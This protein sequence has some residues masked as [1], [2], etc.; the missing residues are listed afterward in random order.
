ML[1]DTVYLKPSQQVLSLWSRHPL[2][3][4]VLLVIFVLVKFSLSSF[5]LLV[6]QGVLVHPINLINF[7]VLINKESDGYISLFVLFI[8]TLLDLINFPAYWFAGNKNGLLLPH[9][10]TDQGDSYFCYLCFLILSTLCFFFNI[11]CYGLLK[12]FCYSLCPQTIV[13][14]IN[15]VNNI[16]KMAYSTFD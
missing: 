4:F 13:P 15:F 8:I 1:H 2:V 16:C 3:V 10:T 5:I 7:L 11:M 9:T 12:H 14:P 6:S